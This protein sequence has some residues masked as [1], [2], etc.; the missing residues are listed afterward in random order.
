MKFIIES[1]FQRQAFGLF[2][3]VTDHRFGVIIGPL[4][5]SLRVERET[6]HPW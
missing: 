4:S 1:R 2:I 6:F 3:G 5:V